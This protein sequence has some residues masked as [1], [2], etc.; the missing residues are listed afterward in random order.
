MP[1]LQLHMYRVAGVAKILTEISDL[2]LDKEQI[3]S[4][5]LLHDMGNILKFNLQVFPEFLQPEGLEYWEQV[6]EEYRSKYGNNEHEATLAIA[7]ELKVSTRTYD[8]LLSIGFTKAEE[9][10]LTDD[11]AKK[12]CDYADTRVA[13]YGVVSLRERIE[14]GRKRYVKR[15]GDYDIGTFTKLA[16]YMKQIEEQIYSHTQKPASFISDQLVNQE[17]ENLREFTIQ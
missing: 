3:I 14:E 11:Y 4:A 15:T 12:I 2:A 10:Y 7:Q 5:C 6:K 8:L 13:P 9:N 16:N 1:S 17:I